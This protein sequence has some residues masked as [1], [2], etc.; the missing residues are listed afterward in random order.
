MTKA[1]ATENTPVD[2]VLYEPPTVEIAGRKYRIRRLGLPDT[3]RVVRILGRGVAMLG[4]ASSLDAGQVM[5]VLVASMT[6]NE[7][8][9]MALIASLIG[10][11]RKELNDPERF[12]MDTILV[13]G[14]ALAEHQDLKEFLGNVQALVEQLP[15]MRT[16]SGAS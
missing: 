11:D 3:F 4:G 16:R 2:P 6:A 1:P 10:V 8:E 15:E 9:V 7:D 13:V 14:K 12:P 5:Q